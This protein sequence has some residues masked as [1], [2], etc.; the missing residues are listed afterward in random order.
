MQDSGA[1]YAAP[2]RGLDESLEGFAG[3]SYGHN[4][5]ERESKFLKLLMI[6]SIDTIKM[7]KLKIDL[8]YFFIEFIIEFL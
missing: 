7:V 1:R 6:F 3:M 8:P 5:T 2:V 4:K